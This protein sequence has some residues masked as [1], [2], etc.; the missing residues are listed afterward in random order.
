MVVVSSASLTSGVAGR[1]ATALF[2]IARERGIL[3]KTKSDV[4]ALEAALADSADLREMI[5]SPVFGRDEM[6]AAMK[7]I[8]ARMDLGTEV[9]STLGLMAENRRLFV[10]PGLLAAMKALIAADRGE[11]TAEVASAKPLTEAQ[12][13]ALRETLK[14]SAG[15]DVELN[16]TVDETLIGGLVVR[17]GSRMVD[18]SIRTKL[19][20]L[21]NI[22]KEVG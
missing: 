9:A 6:A 20:S 16:L 22:M 17:L 7:A 10:L 18:S 3:A 14:A 8:A 5:A 15:K 2:E 4:D 21:Q 13:A 1:Y 19:A 12:V 11:V